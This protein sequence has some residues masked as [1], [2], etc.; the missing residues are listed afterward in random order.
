MWRHRSS[1]SKLAKL[2]G[3]PV[4]SEFLGRG[5]F[6]RWQ[7]TSNQ[8]QNVTGTR[9]SLLSSCRFDSERAFL[10]GNHA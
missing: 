6:A 5:L 3:V 4:T 1:Q 2:S 7:V 10:P 9:E 8:D